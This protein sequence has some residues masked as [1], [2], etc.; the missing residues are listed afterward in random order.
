MLDQLVES[1]SNTR[2]NTRKGGFILTT[3]II[4][5]SVLIGGW[6]Y[7]LFAKEYGVT[8]E[9]ELSTLVAP[10]PIAEEEP[11]PPEPEKE[12]EKKVVQQ[13]QVEVTIRK[14]N[15]LR[16]DEAPP[17]E[18]PPVST[19]QSTAKARPNT[20][21]VV[22]PNATR[23]VT[24]SGPPTATRGTGEGG[25]SPTG[26][27][28]APEPVE[29]P[30]PKPEVEKPKPPPPPPPPPPSKPISGGVV[31]GKATSL[32]QPA[33]P[34]AARAVRASGAVNVQVLIDEN[35]SVVSANAVS[36]HPLLR[37][38][39]EGAARRARFAPTKLSG[40]PVK[41]NGVI[42]YNFVL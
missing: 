29:K 8:D 9:L 27:A 3:L 4:M 16:L 12:P 22:D 39:A 14:D 17:K 19:V 37:Q 7:S 1:R 38:A 5:C 25:G 23:E 21:F 18:P 11:P 42:V 15:I 41:V 28:R 34:P 13:E 6:V 20:A 31:N 26:I 33:Y 36:G 10:V 35:G 24:A 32:P 2:E 40:Q 30:D